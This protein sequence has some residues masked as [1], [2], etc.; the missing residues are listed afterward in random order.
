MNK[1]GSDLSLGLQCVGSNVYLTQNAAR[2]G[3]N[4][5]FLLW[6]WRS[7]EKGAILGTSKAALAF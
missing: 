5:I 7:L 1:V 6:L 3:G 2:N 4:L